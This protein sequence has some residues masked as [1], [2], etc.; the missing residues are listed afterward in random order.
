MNSNELHTKDSNLIE[1][2]NKI[3]LNCKWSSGAIENFN[4]SM[5]WYKKKQIERITSTSLRV[6]TFLWCQFFIYEYMDDN[7]RGTSSVVVLVFRLW[8]HGEGGTR[9]GRLFEAG[10][11]PGR[12]SG[13][14]LGFTTGILTQSKTQFRNIITVLKQLKTNQISDHNTA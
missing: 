6:C 7:R 5:F 8:T 9:V 3:N 11:D 1:M 10:T 14:F 2:V 4:I 12:L 13:R